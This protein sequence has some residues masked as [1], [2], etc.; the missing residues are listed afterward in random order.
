MGTRNKQGKLCKVKFHPQCDA[1]VQK[2]RKP[3]LQQRSRSSTLKPSL[4]I[5]KCPPE[6]EGEPKNPYPAFA[7][8]THE[9]ALRRLELEEKKR[10]LKL[11]LHEPSELNGAQLSLSETEDGADTT[12]STSTCS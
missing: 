3:Q 10:R 7:Y 12:P 9:I 8:P 11:S 6:T 2:P 5:L 4:F 1:E